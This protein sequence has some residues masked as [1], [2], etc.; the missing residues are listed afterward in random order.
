MKGVDRA[1]S[2]PVGRTRPVASSMLKKW[3]RSRINNI[4]RRSAQSILRERSNGQ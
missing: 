2:C 1:V 4:A 3:R